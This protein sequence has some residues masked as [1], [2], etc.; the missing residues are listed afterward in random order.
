[1]K[2]EK[3]FVADRPQTHSPLGRHIGKSGVE[4]GDEFVQTQWGGAKF[5]RSIQEDSSNRLAL[6]RPRRQSRDPKRGRKSSES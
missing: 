3:S 6:S 5:D 4:G 1:M 2:T